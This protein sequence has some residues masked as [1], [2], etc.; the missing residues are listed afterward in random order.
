MPLVTAESIPVKGV[1]ASA[2]YATYVSRYGQRNWSS[3]IA[4]LESGPRRHRRGSR[5]SMQKSLATTKK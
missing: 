5:V 4:D 3:A 2:G 1:F